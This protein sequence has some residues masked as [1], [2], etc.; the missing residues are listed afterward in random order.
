MLIKNYAHHERERE[1]VLS[2]ILQIVRVETVYQLINTIRLH[3]QVHNTCLNLRYSKFMGKDV[4]T[5]KSLLR[6]L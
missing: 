3:N 5:L 1:T 2:K 4:P 6:Y